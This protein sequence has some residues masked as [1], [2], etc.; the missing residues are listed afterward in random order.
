MNITLSLFFSVIYVV[1]VLPCCTQL[2]NS[3]KGFA[4]ICKSAE[5]KNESSVYCMKDYKMK[6]S[7]YKYK[8]LMKFFLDKYKLDNNK[9]AIVENS[10]GE[11]ENYITYGNFFKKVLSFSHSL[12]TYEGTGVPEKI[13]NE[14]KNN[15]KFRLL[16][17]YGNNSTNWLI[18]DCACMIS[19]VTT[20][21]MHSKFSIDIIID[22]LN[23][24]KL[25]WLCLDLDLV[26]GLLCR[27]NELP[28]LKKLIILD[29]LTKR[30]EMK[31]ENEEKSNGSRKSSN[32]QK[33]NESDKRE[34][35]SLC[36]LECDKEKIEKI[37][38]LKEKAKTL[39]LSI[40]VFDNMTENKI[41]NVTVQNEDPNFIASIVYTSGTSGKPKGAMLS[42][43]NLYNGVIPACDCNII[44]KYPLTTH[45]S[46]LPVSHIYERVVFFIA[47]F[48]GVKI[49]IWSRDIKF[50]NTDICNSK[51]EIILGVPKVFNRMYA[52]IMTEINNLSRCKKWI[53]KQAINLRKGKNNGNFSKVVEG[54]TNISR[55]I[56][57]KIN[58]NMDVILN[59]GGKLSPEV[60]EGL[61]V[62]L[63]VKYYQ[64]YGLTESTGPIFLQD[65]DDCNTESMGVAVSPSTRYKVRTWEI[66]KAT[67]TIPKGELLIKS[68]SMFSGYFLEKESTEHAF[69]NDG[70]FKTGDIVQIND[71]GSLTFLDRSKG[72]VKLSQG[73]YI[74]TEMINNLYSQIPFVNF[75][76]AYGDDSMDGPLGI[77][78]VDKHKLFTFL[79]N[80]NMLKTTGVDEKN[81]SEKLI[82]ETLND[83][84]YVDYVKG[85]MMEIY[86][87][88]NLNRYNV[89]ND[90]YL[91]SKP[92]DTTNY[93]T[94]T[95]KIR[96]FNVFK[97]FSFFI[98]EVKKKY[99][100][101]LSGNSTGSMNNG[102]SGSK[103]D[104]K[105]GSKD[106]IKSGSK[107]D[108]KSGSKADIKSGS[109]DDIKSG[110]KDD[111][112]SGSKADIKSGS[113]DDIK[114][115]SE[116]EIKNGKKYENNEEK[117]RVPGRQSDYIKKSVL[118][119]ENVDVSKEVESPVRKSEEKPVS[120][121]VQ[122]QLRKSAEKPIGKQIQRPLPY[123][124]EGDK[125]VN[126]MINVIQKG[127]QELQVNV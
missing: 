24:T 90:I 56:K 124:E 40:I 44:K 72:L 36:A 42:N 99:E 107:D 119:S 81:F 114:G 125:K 61:S 77:I 6:S 109:K 80:D 89:I 112:K 94:P 55:K 121:T 95:L 100:E 5:N 34:D 38:S 45:L 59:G 82:D 122:K 78:S 67:D 68:D 105:G 85:K 98:D 65:V 83:P 31:I 3:K 54:I 76:V 73:E 64:G 18:T 103:S 30:S 25:E 102:K 41:A 101:K 57:D 1:Y 46:Y 120:K 27:K 62:L 50:L 115:G 53:A 26:E 63:N 75:C 16:G 91:T 110:S 111:I 12:N 11:P 96:R 86:K 8:H 97:D 22:I 10:C 23:N 93:L 17:L 117:K 79:K 106:D 70:Y 84:I 51:G 118:K 66:Y 71:N 49:N 28:Y 33:Y 48:L 43:R 37:N 13:Y 113:K 4:E 74:E 88:T 127:P 29:N 58:P 35:I 14:E 9:I 32:K 87:K 52:T 21:V 39:G 69:T 116:E 47:L 2:S 126:E 7:I 92:W 15:G 19:G 104:I 20:L 123:S 60:A 108:I